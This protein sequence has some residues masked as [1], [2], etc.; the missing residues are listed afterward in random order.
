MFPSHQGEQLVWNDYKNWPRSLPVRWSSHGTSPYAHRDCLQLLVVHG[1][2]DR[3]SIRLTQLVSYHK[4]SWWLYV[5]R[6][7]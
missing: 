5:R 3:V 7:N 1:T 2:A 4:S 6:W